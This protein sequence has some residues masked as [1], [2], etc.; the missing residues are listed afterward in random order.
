ML[1]QT[2]Q[3]M[4]AHA[5]AEFPRESCGFVMRTAAGEAYRPVANSSA[6]P[7]DSFRIDGEAYMAAEEEAEI[8]AVVHSHPRGPNGPTMAD[9]VACDSSG[10]PWY[11][12][13]VHCDVPGVAPRALAP[14]G[15]VPDD[16]QAPLIGRPFAH[17]VLD[18]YT[19]IRD[20]FKRVRGIT[21]MD[22]DRADD[23]WHHGGD[24]YDQN[25]AVAGFRKLAKGEP[26]KPGDMIIMQVRSPVGNHGGIYLGD[27][28][29]VEPHAA[30]AFIPRPGLLHHFYGRNSEVT[31][32]GG[33]WEQCTL[34]AAR[35]SSQE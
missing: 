24:L 22:F 20:W 6:T 33:M 25:L 17:G 8:L 16:F 30:G 5:V 21:L 34:F 26:L 31:V 13:P 35:H 29:L 15:F 19:L 12:I 18:C 10:L 28:G 23:W 27:E 3:A 7:E 9:R 2:I 14:V 1:K 4:Q 32:Y 11:V